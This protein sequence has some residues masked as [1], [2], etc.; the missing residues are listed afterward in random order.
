VTAFGARRRTAVLGLALA[1][2]L[3]LAGTSF[4]AVP[5]SEGLWRGLLD[6]PG[7]LRI[8]LCLAL[9]LAAAHWLGPRGAPF[10]V[11]LI[12]L[13][14]LIPVA[15]GRFLPLLVFQGPVLLLV[16]LAAL[17]VAL[18]RGGPWRGS[19]ALSPTAAGIAAFLF[20]ALLGTRLPGPAGPQGDEPHYLTMAE[21]LRADG[22]L[23]L[24]NQ[25]R[26]RTYRAF[27]AGDLEAHTSPASPK[28]TLY[29]VHTP[30][31]AFLILPA[32]VLGGYVGVRLFLSALASLA[33]ALVYLL[34]R[35]AT[36]NESAA[37]ASWAAF[38]LLPPLAFYA[39]AVYP[40]TPA[41]LAT[42]A[43]LLTARRDPGPRGALLAGLAAAALPW[44]HPKFLPLAV[45][46]LG[47][48]LARRGPRLARIV[49][50]L[51]FAASLA[52]FLAWMRSTYGQA[53][54]SAAYGPGFASDISLARIPRGLLAL[55]LDRQFGLFTTA[56]LWVL[57]APGLLALWRWRPGDAMRAALIAC[58][59]LGVGASFSM[60]WGGT[61]P[62]ARFVVPA[63]PALAVALAL[64]LPR[65]P[66]LSAACFGLSLGVVVTAA[67]APRALHNRADGD[68][69]LFRV[70]TPALDVDGLLPSFVAESF[71]PALRLDPQR[72]TLALIRGLDDSNVLGLEGPPSVATLAIPLDLPEAPWTLA[73]GE[74]RFS[75]RLDLPPGRYRVSVL[76]RV[77]E[78]QPKERVARVALTEDDETLADAYLQEGRPSPV[79]EVALPRGARRLA[80]TAVG[81]QGSA[82]VEG[83]RLTPLDVVPMSRR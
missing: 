78:A 55:F 54:L 57:A 8:A 79:F 10:H 41:A 67:L 4:H 3:A 64:A 20:Y 25:F 56:P 19:R 5:T 27:F 14:P 66:S 72:A 77:L 61:C 45:V 11:L 7:A 70:L 58:A 83:V 1:A 53:A 30:G 22:D 81:L 34:A 29:S 39:L 13:A 35:D 23:D 46:G 9:G 37:R 17:A 43:F 82:L 76:G 80:A 38:A 48:T 15:T 65:R 2:P 31:L 40:E 21:S 12:A 49:S 33:G 18:V 32:Y 47:L 28:G 6:P 60:W 62:P 26:D 59:T 24:K 44:L 75:R 73:P 69:A 50:G 51:L 36:L 63:L 52:A 74:M 42:A 16:A 71:V 68:S